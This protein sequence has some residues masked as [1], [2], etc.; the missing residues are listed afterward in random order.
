MIIGRCVKA[1]P[2]A[3]QDVIEVSVPRAAVDLNDSAHGS[4]GVGDVVHGDVLRNGVGLLG[5]LEKAACAVP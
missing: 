3:D 4:H 2:E 5:A 1:F